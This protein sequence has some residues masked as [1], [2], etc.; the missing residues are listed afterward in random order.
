MLCCVW[1]Q[2]L[3][4]LMSRRK[5]SALSG[6]LVARARCRGAHQGINTIYASPSSYQQDPQLM[7]MEFQWKS[8]K[9]NILVNYV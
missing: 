8:C 5:V 3:G 9:C 2:Q 4:T 1:L 7:N 6:A